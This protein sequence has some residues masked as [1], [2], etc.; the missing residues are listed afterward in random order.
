MP[1]VFV[2]NAATLLKPLAIDH[3][4]VDCESYDVDISVI[5]ESHFKTK[6]SDS[7]IGVNGYTVF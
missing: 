6:H 4:A 5:S 7:V 3:L 2:L 1:S